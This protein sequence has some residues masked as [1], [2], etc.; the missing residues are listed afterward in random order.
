MTTTVEQ[1]VRGALL[2]VG[3]IDVRNATPT[4]EAEDTLAVFNDMVA[5]W[6]AHGVFTG[7]GALVL[8]DA[9]PLEDQHTKALKN[10][11]AVEIAPFFGKAIPDQVAYD[12]KQGWQL[13]E[14]E[15]KVI[16]KLTMDDTLQTMPSQRRIW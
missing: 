4:A 5:S 9:S 7:A 14:A 1:I 15:F 16:Q 12:A 3:V 13:I 8:S 10:L 6:P 11:L 2:L